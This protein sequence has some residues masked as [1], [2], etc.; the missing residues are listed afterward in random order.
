M[1]S[2]DDVILAFQPTL[3]TYTKMR[4]RGGGGGGHSDRSKKVRV[5]P[6]FAAE[7]GEQLQ[8]EEHCQNNL[9]LSPNWQ[10]YCDCHIVIVTW[11]RQ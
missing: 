1:S 10:T 5:V 9:M 3:F 6:H 2:P 7:R 11:L 8:R 4:T